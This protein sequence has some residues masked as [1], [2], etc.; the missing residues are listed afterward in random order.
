MEAL[1]HTASPTQPYG[2]CTR[3]R[4]FGNDRL[5]VRSHQGADLGWWDLATDEGHPDH[6]EMGAEL[7]KVVRDWMD[8]EG[9]PPRT[10]LR[11]VPAVQS[12]QSAEDATGPRRAAGFAPD[13]RAEVAAPTDLLTNR[14]GEQLMRREAAEAAAGMQAGRRFLDAPPAE[15]GWSVGAVGE[16]LVA[17]E[18]RKLSELDPRWGFIN[19]IPV[20]AKGTDIDHLVIG[21]GGVFTIN[22]K[23]HRDANIW[24]AGDML[25]VNG[26]KTWYVRNARKE[27]ARAT[28]LLYEATGLR[29]TAW[30]MVV[31]VGA[32]SITI[33]ESPSDVVVVNRR[34]ILSFFQNV[35]AVLDKSAVLRL[36]EAARDSRTWLEPDA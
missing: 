32:A 7:E 25:M 12:P 19:S 10:L 21:P 8:R 31:P 27:A 17:D 33:K 30:G 14:A 13:V 26:E 2:S 22:T 29:V 24:V 1:V 23:H 20:N 3:W 34:R 36:F 18:L 9:V 6:P 5:Y 4:R 28:A 35:P 15:S 11:E 16:Q